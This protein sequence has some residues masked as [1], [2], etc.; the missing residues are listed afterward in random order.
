MCGIAG[1]ISP[2]QNTVSRD[3][4]QKMTEAIKHRGPESDGFWISKTGTVG[5]G[6]RRLSIIDLSPAGAQP[7][8]YMDR[9]SITY[10]G[11]LYNYIEL[12]DDLKSKKFSFK[13]DSDTE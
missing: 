1:I 2:N 12:R 7:M 10:N 6:H 3:R 13:T 4:L 9:Y 8:H 11:E 5:F